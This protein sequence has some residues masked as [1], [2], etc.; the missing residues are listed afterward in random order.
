MTQEY[1]VDF[2]AGTKEYEYT[3]SAEDGRILEKDTDIDID[4]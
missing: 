2:Y 4:F 1:D 3:I